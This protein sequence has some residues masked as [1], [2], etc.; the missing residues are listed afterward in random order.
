MSWTKMVQSSSCLVALG[1]GLLT[2]KQESLILRTLELAGSGLSL[3]LQNQFGVGG[4]WAC[5]AALRL[6][7]GP[8]CDLPWWEWWLPRAHSNEEA[9][10]REIRVAAAILAVAAL[11][12]PSL[13]PHILSSHC[14]PAWVSTFRNFLIQLFLK[15][16]QQTCSLSWV[17]DEV[18][19]YI[20][21]PKLML[22]WLNPTLK[23]IFV[24]MHNS[25]WEV[26]T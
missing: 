22:C 1:Y 5:C 25:T 13:I 8:S 16:P 17:I 24:D 26:L 20:R 11:P 3:L 21:N 9:C 12:N 18:L 15:H 2:G 4:C 19:A 23:P 14:H 6:P 7:T 10:F